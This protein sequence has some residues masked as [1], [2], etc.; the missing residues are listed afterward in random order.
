MHFHSD[1]PAD[2]KIIGE[3]S[4]KHPDGHDVSLEEANHTPAQQNALRVHTVLVSFL[5]FWGEV[6]ISHRQLRTT[7]GRQEKRIPRQ[8]RHRK[9]QRYFLLQRRIEWWQFLL[10]FNGS[11][12]LGI[13]IW[14]MK[15]EWDSARQNCNWN[16]KLLLLC[17]ATFWLIFKLLQKKNSSFQNFLKQEPHLSSQVNS[18]R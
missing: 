15:R 11:S 6:C 17:S 1:V 8:R 9:I 12:P 5:E 13:K 10:L 16:E 4:S 2:N 18:S 3:T 7:Q 14:K